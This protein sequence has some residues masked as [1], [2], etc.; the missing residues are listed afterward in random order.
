MSEFERLFSIESNEIHLK[1]NL[2]FEAK[3]ELVKTKCMKEV[4]DHVEKE[5]DRLIK[6]IA[7]MK[8]SD[9]SITHK[10]LKRKSK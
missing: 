7:D 8:T 1:K 4:T 10:T 5:L 3:I 9:E 2:D 6:K